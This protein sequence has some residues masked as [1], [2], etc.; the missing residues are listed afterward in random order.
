MYGVTKVFGE[1]LGE[2]YFR[3]FG[4]D[5]RALRYPGVIS[6][7]ALPGGGTTDYAVEIYYEAIKKVC[8][9]GGKRGEKSMIMIMMIFPPTTQRGKT[10]SVLDSFSLSEW[11]PPPLN[12]VPHSSSPSCG[13]LSL[14]GQVQLLLEGGQRVAD[15][16]HA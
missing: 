6:A 12:Q 2:Y 14:S 1:L 3:K 7:E 9:N 5:Y 13:S 10:A 15:D 11:P 8:F 16:V 4:V